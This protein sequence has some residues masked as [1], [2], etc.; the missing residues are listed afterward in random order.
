MVPRPVAVDAFCGA[1]GFSLGLEQAGFDVKLAFD[2]DPIH[3]ATHAANFPRSATL[4]AEAE[5]VTG[6]V[7]VESIGAVP[8]LLAGGPPC[9]GFSAIGGRRADDPRNALVF[10]FARLVAEARPRYFLFENVAGFMQ[11][12]YSAIREELFSRFVSAGYSI[13]QPIQILDA[14][15]FDVPQRRKRV[16]LLGY[17]DGETPPSY[18]MPHGGRPSVWEAI[19]DLPSLANRSEHFER[20]QFSGDLGMPS[21]YAAALR[22]SDAQPIGGFLRT[23]HS[24][25]VARRFARTKPGDRE[26]VSRFDR[27]DSAG[28]STT[29]R[30]GTPKG[31]GKFTAARPIPSGRAALHYSARSCS[32]VVVSRRVRVSPDSLA[33][34]PAGGQRN[35]P[36]AR[37]G[38]WSQN[39][40]SSRRK[41]RLR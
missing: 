32:T 12:P 10:D 16:F 36:E 38:G 29:L 20:D 8:D 23:R 5:S 22:R 13:V 19:G 34:I 17:A 35:T 6:E 11:K 26:Q 28:I 4:T 27:L 21:P 1:G 41:G 39:P 37:C 31:R 15:D 40:T 25:A 30:A 33:R 7:I 18:P 9:Q 24:I 14:A 2:A 3:A